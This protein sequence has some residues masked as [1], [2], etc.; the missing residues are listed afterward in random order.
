MEF[1]S[2]KTLPLPS[3]PVISLEQGAPV[4]S[5][6]A[7]V[8]TVGKPLI[9]TTK[10]CEYSLDFGKQRK[11]DI[12]P[13]S[14]D[15]G[16]T[17]HVL[18]DYT[19]NESPNYLTLFEPARLRQ[20][21]TIITGLLAG[22]AERPIIVPLDTIASVVRQCYTSNRPQVGGI[23]SRYIF[24]SIE[25]QRNDRRDIVDRA[26]E[27]IVTSIRTEYELVRQNNSLTI[28]NTLY[29]DFNKEGLRAHSNIKVNKRRPNK[30]F[31]NM[32]Y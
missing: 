18:Y 11:C 13:P 29:G 7:P 24:P 5:V 8:S 23:Y 27:I 20:M 26:I 31:F 19:V 21:Q 9:S 15:P 6:G 3:T 32:R 17:T 28:W 1:C 10:A 16:F 30:L 4:T 14:L 12:G 2:S 22:V 25:G